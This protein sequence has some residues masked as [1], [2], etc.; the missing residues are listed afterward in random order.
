M[1]LVQVRAKTYSSRLGTVAR[2][3]P[4]LYNVF[5]ES[6]MIRTR[7]AERSRSEDLEPW[8][9]SH[10]RNVA[11]YAG[12]PLT[13][14]RHGLVESARITSVFRVGESSLAPRSSLRNGSCIPNVRPSQKET[15]APIPGGQSGADHADEQKSAPCGLLG[16]HDGSGECSRLHLTDDGSVEPR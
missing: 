7:L 1:W 12:S 6:S 5:T 4:S 14:T 3:V 16:S 11:L 8:L 15:L 10:A 2:V 9:Y 13:R